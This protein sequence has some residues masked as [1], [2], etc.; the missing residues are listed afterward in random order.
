MCVTENLCGNVCIGAAMNNFTSVMIVSHPAGTLVNGSNNTFTYP[1]LSNVTLMC[2][3]TPLPSATASFEWSVQECAE[4]FPINKTNQNI[5]G[6]NL[7][8]NDAGT[9]NCSVRDG[10][11][12][13]YSD[14]FTLRISCK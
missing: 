4:C 3:T 5:T 9:F 8:P 12:T 6:N 13:F 11:D 7:T 1:I 14:P 10:G 2:I